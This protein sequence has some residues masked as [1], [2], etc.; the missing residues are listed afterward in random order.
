M[1]PN[2]DLMRLEAQVQTEFETQRE[3]LLARRYHEGDQDVYLNS[4]SLEYLGLHEENKFRMNICRMVVTS[5]LDELNLVGIDTGEEGEVRPLSEWASAV[6]NANRVDSLQ[7]DVHVTALRDRESFVIVDWDSENGRPRFTWMPRYTSLSAD[8]DDGDEMGCYMIYPDDDYTQ[9]PQAAVKRWVELIPNGPMYTQ[10]R[11][12]TVYYPNRI[13]RFAF[14]AGW[15]QYT[16]NPDDEWPIIWTETGKL[17]G[18]PLGIPV[19]HFKNSGLR[20]EAWDAIPMQDAVNKLL[21]DILAS[22]DL[23]GFRILFASGFIPT[24]DGKP[25]AS[26]NSNMANISPGQFIGTTKENA[27]LT[28]IDGSSPVPLTEVLTTIIQHTAHITSTPPGRFS[29]E[30]QSGDSQKEQNKP[31]YAKVEDRRV[32]FG[33]AWEDVMNMARKLENIWGAKTL[34]TALVFTSLWKH[35]YTFDELVIKKNLGV[36]Q[37]QIW[38]E[39]GYTPKEIESMKMMD[40]YQARKAAQDASIQASKMMV[41]NVG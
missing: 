8:Q 15:Q 20:P 3:V 32:L 37:E 26:D 14:G 23:T 21:I 19:I 10:R 29:S 41:S 39:M 6:L 36:P 12:M 9:P 31:F 34:D 25:L 40:E 24:S 4:R 38:R 35:S 7:K 33:N 22:A 27:R 1:F 30:I 16:T 18:K 13:E 28:A 5:V 17:D 2:I 11:R